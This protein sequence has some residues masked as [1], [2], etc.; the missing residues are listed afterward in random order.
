MPGITREDYRPT[1]AEMLVWYMFLELD[2]VTIIR[3]LSKLAEVP[4]VTAEEIV[5]AWATYDELRAIR[6]DTDGLR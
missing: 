1:A 5:E 4:E 6:V 3:M 2:H